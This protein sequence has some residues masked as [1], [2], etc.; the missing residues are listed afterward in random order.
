MLLSSMCCPVAAASGHPQVNLTRA[1]CVTVEVVY[2]KL[3][4]ALVAHL[5]ILDKLSGCG[6]DYNKSSRCKENYNK[7]SRCGGNYSVL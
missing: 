2:V 3:W 7:S 6:E 5:K 1:K 4:V